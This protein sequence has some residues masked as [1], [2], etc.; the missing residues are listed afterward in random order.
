MNGRNRIARAAVGATLA[1]LLTAGCAPQLDRIEVGVQ[2]NRDEIA[3]LQA[4]NKR[5]LQ[6]VQALGQLLRMDRDA[7]DESSAMRLAKLNQV[8][9]RLDQLLQKLD[10]NAEYMR[11]LSARVDLLATRA[12]VPTLG[13]YKEYSPPAGAA[14]SAL[15]EEGRAILESAELDRSRGNDELARAGFTEFLEKYPRAEAAD[16][17]MYWLADLDVGDGRT[18]DALAGYQRLIEEHPQS[19]F[20]PAALY[21]ARAC[22][23]DLGRQQ[24]AWDY[25]GRLLQE[26]PQSDEA[27]QL[28]LERG[29]G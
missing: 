20:M 29:D 7:G 16:R 8:A 5:M 9:T 14:A 25:G 1:A 10:D 13:E 19:E 15:P 11:D 24:E 18:E 26:Y 27:A 21:K 17:A 3:L 22:L 28:R 23:L 2:E 6:E 12:G 4:E